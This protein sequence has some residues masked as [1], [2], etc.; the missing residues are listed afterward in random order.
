MS[1]YQPHGFP[2]EKKHRLYVVCRYDIWGI[3][4]DELLVTSSLQNCKNFHEA[5]GD[6]FID[7]VNLRVFFRAHQHIGPRALGIFL[8]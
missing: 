8:C 4:I 5:A 1:G 3:C 2:V 6:C 7:K